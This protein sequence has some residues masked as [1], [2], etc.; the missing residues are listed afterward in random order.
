M[1]RYVAK[2]NSGCRWNEHRYSD[3]EGVYSDGLIV[4][5]GSLQGQEGGIREVRVR[6]RLAF[7]V[8]SCGLCRRRKGL[9][10]KD[11]RR[12]PASGEGEEVD[13]PSERPEG[14]LP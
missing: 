7:P 9:P 13:V 14:D 2:R 1:F 3:E 4:I 10:A 5:T 12:P 8:F 11:R 6:E